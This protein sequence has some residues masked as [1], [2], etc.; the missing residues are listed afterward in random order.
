MHV[1]T[2]DVAFDETYL[3]ALSILTVSSDMQILHAQYLLKDILVAHS[4]DLW[5]SFYIGKKFKVMKISGAL[6]ILVTGIQEESFKCSGVPISFP[7]PQSLWC[8]LR[9]CKQ[10]VSICNPPTFHHYITTFCQGSL[11]VSHSA[12]DTRT[13]LLKFKSCP[14]GN[15]A[16][17]DFISVSFIN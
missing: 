14:G 10:N 4:V 7:H 5:L 17:P 3:Q 1:M 11:F 13:K 8:G 9:S 16:K 2:C 6:F 15:F 12:A